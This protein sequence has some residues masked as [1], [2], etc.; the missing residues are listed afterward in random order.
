MW[1]IAKSCS[2]GRKSQQR[3]LLILPQL[4]A[5]PT[6]HKEDP[7]MK[8]LGFLLCLVLTLAI[9]SGTAL[10][11][12][13]VGDGSNY[14]TTYYSNANTSSAPDAVVRVI[15][16]GDTGGNL[17]ASYYVFDNSQE[18]Q[19][20][21][22]CFISPDGINSEDVNSDLTG[23]S[24]TS[25][26]NTNGVIKVIGSSTGD[27]TANTLAAGLHGTATHIQRTAPTSGSFYV[28]ETAL[29][30]SNLAAGEQT[31]LQMLCKFAIELGS[32]RGT[33]SC[34]PEDSDF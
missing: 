7:R 17:Y 4:Q 18:L 2:E 6:N 32:G 21:C 24:L 26:V 20:C 8:K 10:A 22:N 25:K 11:A 16:D 19:E 33:C 30:D 12:P 5:P 9:A 13:P 1:V 31:M 23:N 27:P 28:T 14:F 3:P 29:A 15:N 34:T